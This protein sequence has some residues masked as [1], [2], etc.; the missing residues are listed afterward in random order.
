VAPGQVSE[1]LAV[2]DVEVPD[3]EPMCDVLSPPDFTQEL[4]ELLLNAV[5]ELTG[6]QIVQTRQGVLEFAKMHG[7]IDG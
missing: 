3:E 2:P 1:P 7:W 4:T 5:P 6:Q